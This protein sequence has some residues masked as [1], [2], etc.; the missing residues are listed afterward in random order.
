MRSAIC[1][2]IVLMV[3]PIQLTARTQPYEWNVPGPANFFEPANW[4]PVGVPGSYDAAL[5]RNGGTCLADGHEP[6]NPTQMGLIYLVVGDEIG[7]GEFIAQFMNISIDSDLDIGGNT[8]TNQPYSGSFLGIDGSALITDTADLSVN[9][10]INAGSAYA[11][12]SSEVEA[13][14]SLTIERITGTVS[15]LSDIDLGYANSG[16]TATATASG[17]LTIIDSGAIDVGME[18]NIADT[19][20][21]ESAV[22]N[23]TGNATIQ[24]VG[25]VTVTGDF[26]V[27]NAT[28][29]DNGTAFADATLVMEN[30][31]I[32]DIGGDFDILDGYTRNM[33]GMGVASAIQDG[34]VLIETVN[35]ISVAGE[36]H[37]GPDVADSGTLFNT[38]LNVTLRDI[39]HLNVIGNLDLLNGAANATGGVPG[40]TDFDGVLTIERSLVD[41]S[42]TNFNEV[43]ISG[44]SEVNSAMIFNLIDTTFNA[45]SVAFTSDIA[46]VSGGG[47]AV[48][49]SM[50]THFNLNRSRFYS[51]APVRF[52][53]TLDNTPGSFQ[54]ML[55]LDGASMADANNFHLGGD[56][57]MTFHLDGLA[58]VGDGT[59]GDPGTYSAMNVGDALLEGEIE[60]EFDFTP[61]AGTYAFD[62]IG[63]SSSTAL[64]D[65]A[66]MFSTNYLPEGF[67][68]DFFGVVEQ[69]GVDI[70]RLIISGTPCLN[71]GDVNF[72]GQIT[73]EDAQLA[74]SIVIG[75]LIPSFAEECA[76]D[77]T[78]N[79][80]VTAEDAQ[81]I[82]GAVLGLGSCV[83]SI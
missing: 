62:L 13:T 80:S 74:F 26:D 41:V 61:P 5:I 57:L 6:G 56:G 32:L 70:L 20:T 53:V 58:R 51:A 29:Y 9:H 67:I 40:N 34:T 60:A 16:Y 7:Q 73:A 1:I 31:Q 27:G 45:N 64:D 65:T 50:T 11:Q 59:I 63:T 66:A 17:T 35:A 12:G 15:I 38:T 2:C 79:D 76:A 49:N 33:S 75:T 55:D 30:V 69:G 48:F 10:D 78:G 21:S 39:G 71:H 14:G 68:V 46:V 37:I 23:G 24:N 3:V 28:A 8:Q 47:G 77:C 43:T 82:F 36:F 83:D 25:M 81:S 72:N 44:N 42:R 52:G 18:F 54:A 19:Y 22:S 4:L